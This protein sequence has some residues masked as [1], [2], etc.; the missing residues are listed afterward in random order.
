MPFATKASCIQREGGMLSQCL[1]FFLNGT[2]TSKQDASSFQK[3]VLGPKEFRCF[4]LVP[5]DFSQG[6]SEGRLAGT[7]A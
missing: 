3:L 1:V 5:I 7:L 2:I 6:N 4:A